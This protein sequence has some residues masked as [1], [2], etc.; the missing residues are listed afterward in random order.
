MLDSQLELLTSI[1]QI[2]NT[3]TY[4][5]LF[6]IQ[7][8]QSIAVQE[9]CSSTAYQDSLGNWTIGI[10]HTPAY[11]GEVW[12]NNTIFETFFNDIYSKAY[13]PVNQNLPWVT[14]LT[15][16]RQWVNYNASFNMGI[17]NW[18]QFTAT[19]NAMQSGNLLGVLSGMQQSQWYNQVTN[20][21]KA[22]MYQ[23]Y[24]NEWVI[25]YLTPEQDSQLDSL[26]NTTFGVSISI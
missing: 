12:S 24:Y 23:Y 10:G 3:S 9:G 25:G 18:L 26:I 17:N 16:P 1:N 22:L 20:R 11:P 6:P 2:F 8:P 21:V 15:L 13:L 7:G 5:T 4:S 19:L 14:S